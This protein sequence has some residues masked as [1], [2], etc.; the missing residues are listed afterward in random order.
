ME[1]YYTDH[2]LWPYQLD[3][4]WPKK[5][6]LLELQT[7]CCCWLVVMARHERLLSG[8]R[9]K[10]S[11]Q[12]GVSI[13]NRQLIGL[14]CRCTGKEGRFHIRETLVSLSKFFAVVT[15]FFSS[16]HR[17]SFKPFQGYFSSFYF[18][19]ILS[20]L[21]PMLKPIQLALFRSL[22]FILY[23]LGSSV[24]RFACGFV[25]SDYFARLPASFT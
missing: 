15:V 11:P 4:K 23:F 21:C 22:G 5:S 14:R 19:L 20:R 12:H 6:K 25:F 10:R 9:T 1:N 16:L 2:A 24:S 7:P 17:T 18:G 13:G 8:V 3:M